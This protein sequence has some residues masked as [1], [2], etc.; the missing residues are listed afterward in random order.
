[1]VQQTDRLQ[2]LLSE[3]ALTDDAFAY[4]LGIEP[5]QAT[6]ICNGR[7]KLTASLARQIEQ[8]FSKPAYWLDSDAAE[9]GPSY[10]LF[11]ADS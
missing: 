7:K 6:A 2:Q 1:M 4:C 5:E 9:Q 8:T 10:D 3:N 11:G